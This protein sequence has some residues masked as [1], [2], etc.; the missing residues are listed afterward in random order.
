MQFKAGFLRSIDN[1]KT[2][3][4]GDGFYSHRFTILPHIKKLYSENKDSMTEQLIKG[5]RVD[6]TN[7]KIFRT[8]GFV[9]L[10]VDTGLIGMILFMLLFII[11][12]FKIIYINKFSLFRMLSF[13]RSLVFAV[14]PFICFCWFLPINITDLT[15]A[16][17]LIIPNGL[18]FN[19]YKQYNAIHAK[20]FDYK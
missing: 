20:N 2:F 8:N 17:I 10:L 5:T 7:I 14:L 9:A 6:D 16:Y 4:I 13:D 11:S 19:W 18:L 12:I 1:V 3:L 15:L